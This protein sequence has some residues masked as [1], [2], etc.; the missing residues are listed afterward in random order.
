M[1]FTTCAVA[2]SGTKMVRMDS[3]GAAATGADHGTS[4]E[5]QEQDEIDRALGAEVRGIRNKRGMTLDDL[6]QAAGIGKRT[7]VR[8]EKGERPMDMRQLYQICLAL[9][10]KPSTIINAMESEVGIQ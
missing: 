2:R 5:A 7:L 8:I 1:T 4:P 10:V 6:A 9:R 3:L